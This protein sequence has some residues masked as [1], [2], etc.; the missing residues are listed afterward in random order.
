LQPGEPIT[1]DGADRALLDAIASGVWLDPPKRRL[2]SHAEWLL[3][4]L[5][6][7]IDPNIAATTAR[8]I[9]ILFA[10]LDPDTLDRVDTEGPWVNEQR[11]QW[12]ALSP[13]IRAQWVIDW[14]RQLREEARERRR[15]ARGD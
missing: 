5:F 1:A 9:H 12:A 6:A 4:R 2:S 3:R 15:T 14:L 8:L 10:E 11:E 7:N 13:A